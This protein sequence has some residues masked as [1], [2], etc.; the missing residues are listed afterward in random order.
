MTI[1]DAKETDA[2]AVASLLG[3]LGYANESR[4]ALERI[5]EFGA[6]E[7]SQVLVAD[8]EGIVNGVIC[9]DVQPLFHQE[10]SIGC[11]M[12]LCVSAAARGQ[13]IGRALVEHIEE[14]ARTMGCIKIAVASGVRREDAH[15]FYQDLGYEE[16]TKRF[17]KQLC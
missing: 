4:F 13:G 16:N 2:E 3:E 1:R 10:G 12:A 11:I 7:S 6:R 15:R 5:K 17:V 8:K 14:I 9:F